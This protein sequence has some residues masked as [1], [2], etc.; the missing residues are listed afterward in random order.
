M[1]NKKLI[2]IFIPILFL[3]GLALFIRIVQYEPLFPDTPDV[4]SETTLQIPIYGEDPIT[5]DK[6][7]PI[8]LIAFED[9]ACDHCKTQSDLLTKI[10]DQY[11]KSLKIIWKILPINRYPIDST[12]SAEYAYCA[13]QQ[14]KFELFKLYAFENGK[15]LSEATLEEIATQIKLDPKKLTTCLESGTAQTYTEAIKNIS[16]Q[17]HIQELPTLFI[18]NKQI[19]PPTSVEGWKTLLNI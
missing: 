7:A 1:S 9:F 16:Q 2:L 8:T 17:L 12:L 11:P 19:Q 18:N 14:G 4:D 6:K 13:N 10:L 3:A 15:N 5:G